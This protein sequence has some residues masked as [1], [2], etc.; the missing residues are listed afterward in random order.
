MNILQLDKLS[1][2]TNLLWSLRKIFNFRKTIE[3][4]NGYIKPFISEDN[5]YIIEGSILLTNKI[6]NLSLF[7]KE[8]NLISKLFETESKISKF[9][10]EENNDFYEFNILNNSTND[11]FNVYKNNHKFSDLESIILMDYI[12][13]R[14]E[15]KL[16]LEFDAEQTNEIKSIKTEFPDIRFNFRNRKLYVSNLTG[17]KAEF[18][19]NI[20]FNLTFFFPYDLMS[21]F[22]KGTSLSLYYYNSEE[23]P[24]IFFITFIINNIH[25]KD[26]SITIKID[27][28][29]IKLQDG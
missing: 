27:N 5:L 29:L 3:I 20:D 9:I 23:E 10:I 2:C 15:K 17:V 13:F 18:D 6:P 21:I 19:T 22:K 7:I 26:L 1:H 12:S 16:I 4:E 14:E 8:N 25:F 28:S 24:E 11:I